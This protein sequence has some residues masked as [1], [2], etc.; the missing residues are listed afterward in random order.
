[1]ITSALTALAV[2]SFLFLAAV[3]LL[4]QDFLSPGTL[5]P[6]S[7]GIYSLG[8]LFAWWF[9]RSRVFF[10]LLL[11]AGGQLGLQEALKT[12]PDLAFRLQNLW[13]LLTVLLPLNF[14]VLAHLRERGIFSFWGLLP[15]AALSLQTAFAVL[16]VLT[17]DADLVQPLLS[18]LFS[19]SGP[20]AAAIPLPPASPL[21][22]FLAALS[23]AIRLRHT[24]HHVDW[25]FLPVSLALLAALYY[26]DIPVAMPIFFS[27]AALMLLAAVI[28]DAYAMAYRDELT[29]IPSRRALQESLLQLSGIYTL[30]MLDI[31][32]FK[33]FNDTYG[34]DVGDDV[35]RLVAS[36]LSTVGGGGKAFRYGGEEFTVI[37]PG[38]NLAAALPHL[39]ALR[40]QIAKTGY[41]Q[42]T[43][44]P[45]KRAPKQLFVTISIGAS[46]KSSRCP[47]AQAVL[48]AADK[49]L[50]RAKEKGRNCVSK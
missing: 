40:E 17:R 50:Y 23:F 29:G 43:K 7:W 42:R 11:L 46:E 27:T 2:P 33:K 36:V 21:L 48:K 15:L 26:R 10:L 6:L 49:A 37:F 20:S 30:A 18:L 39:E 35:L 28:Q 12:G 41:T 34:H 38:K 16:V 14:L 13:P 31:D 9:N 5:D 19:R 25:S 4:R 8:L 22:F 45:R 3:T 32:H 24:R 47:E 1:M 44:A